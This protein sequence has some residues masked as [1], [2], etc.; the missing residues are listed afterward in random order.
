M[1][2]SGCPRLESAERFL[3]QKEFLRARLELAEINLTELTDGER[4]HVQLLMAEIGLHTGDYK[5][6]HLLGP[7]LNYYK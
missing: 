7:A 3:R 5:I 2:I 4:A 6:Q 1:N